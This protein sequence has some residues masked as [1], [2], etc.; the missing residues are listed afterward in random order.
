MASRIR[1]R[2]SQKMRLPRFLRSLAPLNFE[3]NIANRQMQTKTL[4][5]LTGLA[6]ICFIFGHCEESATLFGG[7]RSNLFIRIVKR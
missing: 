3:I 4:P 1:G 6:M 2:F 7:R 5:Y